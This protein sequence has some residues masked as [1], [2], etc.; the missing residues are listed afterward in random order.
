MGVDEWA[1]TW[2]R[3][4]LGS[5]PGSPGS[6]H[7]GATGLAG[8]RTHGAFLAACTCGVIWM[9]VLRPAPVDLDLSAGMEGWKPRRPTETQDCNY[10]LATGNDE[11]SSRRSAT[12]CSRQR[13]AKRDV[14]LTNTMSIQPLPQDV[15]AKIKSSAIITSLNG[16]AYGLLCNSLDA[17]ACK[18]NISVDYSR[19]N[20]SVE[21]DGAGIAPA[22]FQEGEGLGKLHCKSGRPTFVGM[23]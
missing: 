20:C 14:E 12:I 9:W 2:K 15:A 8:A 6:C 19:G 10:N 11:G 3:Q 18:I 1:P 23:G 16:A 5:V 4:G 17:G 21:D 7:T 22:S 13:L